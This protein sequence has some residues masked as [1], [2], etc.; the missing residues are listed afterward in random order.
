MNHDLSLVSNSDS[1]DSSYTCS[2]LTVLIQ[3][4]CS[5]LKGVVL[6]PRDPIEGSLIEIMGEL[7]LLVIIDG[8]TQAPRSSILQH[9]PVASSS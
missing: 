3:N 5:K 1:S 6:T 9:T 7:L 2:G 8:S 4:I